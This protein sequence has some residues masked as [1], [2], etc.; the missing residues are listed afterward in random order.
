M[1][2]VNHKYDGEISPVYFSLAMKRSYNIFI[3][4]FGIFILC[5][6]A[7]GYPANCIPVFFWLIGTLVARYGID[8]LWV[9]W[10][11]LFYVIISAGWISY[12]IYFYGW[13][14]G[15]TNFIMPLML[16][17]MFSVYDTFFTKITF[18]VFLFLLRMALFF[19]CQ[20][21]P[22]IYPLST[23]QMLI[24]QV[25]NTILSFV[26]MGVI[27]ITFSTNLQKAEKHLLLYN[28]ELRQQAGTD[29]L[30]GLYNRRRMEE[31]LDNH[32]AANPNE[33][34]CIAIGDIDFFKSVNDTY[35]HDLSL[36]H[37]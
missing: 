24:L 7:F 15:G 16:M 1:K 5:M 13:N 23:G 6:A 9:R 27:C 36:I 18:T 30:T 32:I 31:I 17:S 4:Y 21:Y 19:H 33:I 14:C 2:L 26:I 29:P 8:H 3:I 20:T 10:N 11:F 12:F 34:F 37:I 28:M 35:G 22:V 25:V